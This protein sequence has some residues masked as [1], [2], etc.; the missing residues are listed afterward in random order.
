[1]GGVGVLSWIAIGAAAGWVIS[2]LMVTAEDDAL[3]GTAAGIVGG[4]LG[5]LAMRLLASPSG[6]GEDHLNT[7]VAVL[8][9][10]LWLTWITSVITSGRDGRP[11]AAAPSVRFVSTDEATRAEDAQ[12]QLGYAAARDRLVDQLRSDAIAHEAEHYGEVGR[13][14]QSVQRVM[15]QGGRPELAKL[16]VAVA[17]WGDWIDARDRGWPPDAGITKAEWPWIA[18]T[19]AAD[20]ES[21]REVTDARVV[22]RFDAGSDTSLGERMQTIAA[23][24]RS[25]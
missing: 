24:I 3:R 5:G 9:G 23:R 8:G 13:R 1:M 19:V 7:S 21:D 12:P 22:A 20:L 14:F 6:P 17:F 16:K 11:A 15:P 10:S 2:R 18:R 4:L 25:G